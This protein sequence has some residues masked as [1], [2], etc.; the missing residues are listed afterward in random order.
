MLLKVAD[1]Q[2]GNFAFGFFNWT[3]GRLKKIFLYTMADV[4]QDAMGVYSSSRV[5]SQISHDDKW[6]TSFSY[7]IRGQESVHVQMYIR[8]M[9]D[10]EGKFPTDFTLH[11]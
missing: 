10:C 9:V 3:C 4:S 11:M 5:Q 1:I 6:K 2:A 8:V 7:L